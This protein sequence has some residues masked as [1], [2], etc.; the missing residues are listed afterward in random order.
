[1]H[2][3]PFMVGALLV[4]AILAFSLFHPAMKGLDQ[5]ADDYEDEEE[6]IGLQ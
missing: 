1:M 5:S 6:G 3:A 4:L 2:Q